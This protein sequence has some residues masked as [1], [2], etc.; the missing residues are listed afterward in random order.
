MAKLEYSIINTLPS[1]EKLIQVL[2]GL[3]EH[4]QTK[5]LNDLSLETM[6]RF[7]TGL[8][9]PLFTRNKVKQLTG[10]GLCDTI[11]YQEVRDKVTSLLLK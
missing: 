8:S 6:C 9:M 11:R 3:I 2:Q 7:L 4:M 10:F 1:D 5:G